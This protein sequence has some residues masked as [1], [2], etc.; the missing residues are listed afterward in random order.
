MMS[1]NE[2]PSDKDSGKTH[3]RTETEFVFRYLLQRLQK[4]CSEFDGGDQ[5]AALMIS[6]VLRTLLKT[7]V[8]KNTGKE[9]TVS[10][11]D[12]LGLQN[13]LFYDTRKPEK[14]ISG[15]TLESGTCNQHISFRGD[16][17]ATLLNI[18]VVPCPNAGPGQCEYHFEPVLDKFGYRKIKFSEWYEQPVYSICGVPVTRKALIEHISE[19][20]GG[21]HFDKDLGKQSYVDF[22]EKNALHIIVNGREML[23]CENP[24]F[25]SLRQIAYEV[26]M[27]FRE[28][29][30]LRQGN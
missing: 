21:A 20:E 2:K 3:T 10:V 23:F 13:T 6:V 1:S 28:T 24:A 27:T 4:F 19:K 29:L 9:I 16:V 25:V 26:L 18:R 30:A 7:T 17:S 5:Y 12:Q 14:G 15:V 11:M 22:R 8:N